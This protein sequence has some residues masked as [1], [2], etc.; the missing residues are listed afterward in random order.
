MCSRICS[1]TFVCR[2]QP[3]VTVN[4]PTF[5]HRFSTCLFPTA[6]MSQKVSLHT[7]TQYHHY[8]D[9]NICRWAL[10]A[11]FYLVYLVDNL[12]GTY[13]EHRYSVACKT[14]Q[15]CAYVQKDRA[16]G[17]SIGDNDTW[18]LR[19]VCNPLCGIIGFPALLPGPLLLKLQSL[20]TFSSSAC[21]IAGHLGDLGGMFTVITWPT[22]W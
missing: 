10:G 13:S 14:H 2:P 22:P 20:S 6:W 8:I 12:R 4:A 15:E 9:N 17:I 18:W 1:L 5:S 7:S 19:P 11:I 16:S 21:P 3:S